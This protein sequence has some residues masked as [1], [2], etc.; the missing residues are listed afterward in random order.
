MSLNMT[1]R[2]ETKVIDRDGHKAWVAPSPAEA[3]DGRV[4]VRLEDGGGLLL[5]SAA[6]QAQPDGSYTVPLSFTELVAHSQNADGEIVLPVLEEEVV[7]GK[8]EVERGR[9]R[10][11]KHVTERDVL[12]DHPLMHEHVN[13]ER[14][15]VNQMVDTPPDIRYEG[16]TMI[17][18]VLEEVVVVEV[19]LMVREEI[20][21]TRQR[22]EVHQPQH[23]TLRR[24]ELNIDSI[25]D[26]IEA[27][28]NAKDNA[29]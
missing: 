21:I 22:E 24:E 14:V 19:R 16:E 13:V 20:R 26:D 12:V 27:P 4:L 3:P 2:D 15:P 10:L 11:T 23:V 6:L 9:F 25:A 1:D 28:G 8:R 17:V 7:V 29:F 18:P 5:D